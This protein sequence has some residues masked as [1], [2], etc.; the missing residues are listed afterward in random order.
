[1]DNDE[2]DRSR[3][4]LKA[5]FPPDLPREFVD[6]IADRVADTY[7]WALD[8]AHNS[9][10]PAMTARL[11]D[12][13]VLLGGD[14]ECKTLYVALC[15]AALAAEESKKKVDFFVFRVSRANET[16]WIVSRYCNSYEGAIEVAMWNFRVTRTRQVWNSG[17]G[18]DVNDFEGVS[19]VE[20]L[21]KY[22][23]TKPILR[24]VK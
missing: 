14:F 3:A 17:Q 21:Q 11:R 13:R 2:Y 5:A 19:E 12:E 16:L 4:F 9:F 24:L 15:V 18:F 23:R 20:S 7:V 10:E 6:F 1:M 8:A 22:E